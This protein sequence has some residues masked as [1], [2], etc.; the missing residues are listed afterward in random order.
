[1]VKEFNSYA[2]G[3]QPEAEL[4]GKRATKNMDE[5]IKLECDCKLAQNALLSQA[6][7]IKEEY[8]HLKECYHSIVV[9][10][11]QMRQK[12]ADIAEQKPA[13]LCEIIETS[14]SRSIE[15]EK[16]T[17]FIL[18]ELTHEVAQEPCS[19][20]PHPAMPVISSLDGSEDLSNCSSEGA[21]TRNRDKQGLFDLSWVVEEGESVDLAAK[22][23][24]MVGY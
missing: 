15:T 23:A 21:T 6:N 24:L 17:F 7:K 3:K 9:F 20:V 10:R 19:G 2:L 14:H 12:L 8:N 18:S 22:S 16:H 11:D 5:I 1:M 4:E 13:A